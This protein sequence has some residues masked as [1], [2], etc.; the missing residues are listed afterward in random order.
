MN[1]RKICVTTT[2]RADYGLLYHLLREIQAD[3][4]LRLQIIATAMHISP[5]FGLDLPADRAGRV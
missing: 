5:E 2:S 1:P 4:G 3:P